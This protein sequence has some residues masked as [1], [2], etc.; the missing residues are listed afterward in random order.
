VAARHTAGGRWDEAG[1]DGKPL[2]VCDYAG[3]ARFGFGYRRCPGEWLSGTGRTL[4][5]RGRGRR[6]S[7]SDV[8]A[9]VRALGV[10]CPLDQAL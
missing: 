3:Y 9:R 7:I 8:V 6:G 4:A 10:N 1:V 2:T 5:V